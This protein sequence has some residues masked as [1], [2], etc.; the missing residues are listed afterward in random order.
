M[1][2]EVWG[3]WH[4]VAQVLLLLLAVVLLLLGSLLVA[5]LVPRA[6]Q[7]GVALW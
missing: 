6:L 1:K 5:L 3:A 2:T 7:A 4:A